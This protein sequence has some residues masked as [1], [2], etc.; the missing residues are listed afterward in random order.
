MLIINPT[1]DGTASNSFCP[2][3]KSSIEMP[4]KCKI[5]NIIT[6]FGLATI[7]VIYVTNIPRKKHPAPR[8]K[9]LLEYRQTIPEMKIK[10]PANIAQI[11]SNHDC[12]VNS[13]S[14]LCMP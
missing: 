7:A 5:P 4:S 1:S 3:P 2:N 6:R 9:L 12:A 13:V 14:Q 10:V 11:I 8:F